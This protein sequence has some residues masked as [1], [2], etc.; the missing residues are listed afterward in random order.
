MSME[1]DVL[2]ALWQR[3]DTPGHDACVVH[4]AAGGWRLS[5]TAVFLDGARPC[6]LGY[7][8]DCDERWN[9]LSATVSGWAGRDRID[10]TIEALAHGAWALNGAEQP[11]ARGCVDVDLGFTPA[12]NLIVIRRLDLQT[13]AIVPAPAAWMPFPELHL[14]RLEQTYRR[15]GIRQYDYQAPD[16]PYEAVLSVDESGLIVD[17]PGLWR[18]VEPSSLF[19][20]SQEQ[21]HD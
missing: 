12:T 14:Q 13:E 21:Q 1:A 2:M 10:V 20:T 5:G 17:Y 8:V 19:A 15:I 16:V 3:L 7:R 9:S 18:R 11:L 4:R 6:Q